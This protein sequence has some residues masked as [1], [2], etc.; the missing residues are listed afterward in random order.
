MNEI[1]FIITTFERYDL[2]EKLLMSIRHYYPDAE[3]SVY[4]DSINKQYIF[5]TRVIYEEQGD[6]GLSY[7]RNSLVK[8][9]HNPYILLLEDDFEFTDNTKIEKMLEIMKKEDADVVGGKVIN[10]DGQVIHFE[11]KLYKDLDILTERAIEKGENPDVVLNFALFNRRV[12]D[13]CL[14][15]EELKLA[16]HNDFYLRLKQFNPKIVYTEEVSIKHN[17]GLNE[18]IEYKQYRTRQNDFLKIMMKKNNLQFIYKST[19]QVIE[20][21]PDGQ[22]KKYRKETKKWN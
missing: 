2:L 10:Y 12:F 19:G 16:E 1:D 5:N 18:S 8:S 14:W 4:N 11:H 6:K 17:K 3:I 9:T 15:D 21:L 7:A 13:K 22:L 20:L